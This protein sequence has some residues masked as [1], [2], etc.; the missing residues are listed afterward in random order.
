MTSTHIGRCFIRWI[1]GV[2]ILL[3]AGLP[4]A[5][6]AAQPMISA[7]TSHA[8]V[9]D[10]VGTVSCWGS[11]YFGQTGRLIGSSLR[12]IKHISAGGSHTCVTSDAGAAKCWGS[13]SHEQLGGANAFSAVP[14]VV[15]GLD[16]RV[17]EVHAGW[18][19]SCALMED[20]LVRCWGSNQQGQL[21]IGIA[22]GASTPSL[23]SGLPAPAAVLRLSAMHTCALLTTGE[24]WCWGTGTPVAGVSNLP[25]RALDAPPDIVKLSVDQ[26]RTCVVTRAG[27]GKCWGYSGTGLVTLQGLE[28]NV[29]ELVPGNLNAC[30]LR[31]DGSVWC[32]G[33]GYYGLL[34]PDRSGENLPMARLEQMPTGIVQLSMG[35]DYACALTLYGGV[36][37]WGKNEYNQLGSVGTELLSST[38]PEEVMG[39]PDAALTLSVSDANA[40]ATLASGNVHCWGLNSVGQLGDNTTT[41]RA[42]PTPTRPIGHTS[43]AVSAGGRTTC[44]TGTNGTI[45][46]WG[47]RFGSSSFDLTPAT[48]DTGTS[49]TSLLVSE[50]AVE[51]GY[52]C[53]AST[54]RVACSRSLSGSPAS[55]AQFGALTEVDGIAG[56]VSSLT[57][58]VGTACVV[59]DGGVKC[60]GDNRYGQLGDG[61]TEARSTPVTPVGLSTGVKKVVMNGAHTCALMQAGP[62]KCWGTNWSG[63]LG[64]GTSASSL[65]PVNAS[66]LPAN[67]DDIAIGNSFTCVL[68][69]GVVSCVGY[70]LPNATFQQVVGVPTDIRAIAAGNFTICA[71]RNNGKVVCWGSNFSGM[72]GRG[73]FSYRPIPAQFVEGVNARGPMVL[74]LR[75]EQPVVG[76]VVSFD[77]TVPGPSVT[78]RVEF[79]IGDQV[80]DG[81]AAIPVSGGTAT[82]QTASLTGG[83]KIARAVYSGSETLPG[84]VAEKAFVV[85]GAGTSAVALSIPPFIVRGE[86][87]RV[88]VEVSGSQATVPTGEVFVSA[89]TSSCV[90]LLDGAGRGYCDFFFDTLSLDR[91]ATA[92]YRGDGNYR[93]AASTST[94]HVIRR[95][96]VNADG[97]VDTF[98]MLLMMRHF[99]GMRGDALVDSRPSARRSRAEDIGAAIEWLR[100]RGGDVDLDGEVLVTTDMLLLLRYVNDQRGAELVRG[101]LGRFAFR[102]NPSEIEAQLRF[103][104][105]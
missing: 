97:Q 34:G 54:R 80:I 37:C 46:C 59:V 47:E 31:R 43:K 7:G 87:T 98:D 11:D 6:N 96:D 57:L 10:A 40:C 83:A 21:G 38:T 61:T 49:P 81:C 18:T 3:F 91:Q 1:L 73:G 84:L 12:G 64:D 32:D 103:L 72:L 15:P 17:K 101:A 105:E 39:L 58:G 95:A 78:G 50:V 74:A 51:F 25:T 66:Q 55:G 75:N 71:I 14:Y 94:F 76:E 28:A 41:N 70:F 93:V 22:S 89:G 30:A 67:A 36:K 68:S 33:T 65:V 90:A 24:L 23:V 60:W 29:V 35:Y 44:S 4:G 99:A 100:F 62:A 85:T 79:S 48:F 104:L 27:E 77:A 86:F 20:G 88:V 8:C 52:L 102:T 9:L 16:S 26:N 69:G 42:T 13:N 45:S 82:C 5:P 92:N 2:P 56:A 53:A 19:H 63:Q